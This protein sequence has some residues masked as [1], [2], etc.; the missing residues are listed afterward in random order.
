[1]QPNQLANNTK[2]NK[3]KSRSSFLGLKLFLG[4]KKSC[5]FSLNLEIILFCSSKVISEF[6]LYYSKTINTKI[7]FNKLNRGLNY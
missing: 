2:K 1:M 4:L 7:Y 5:F 3:A 6:V